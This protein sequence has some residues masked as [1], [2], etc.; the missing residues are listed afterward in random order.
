MKHSMDETLRQLTI[1]DYPENLR[2][3]PGPPEQLWLRGALAP[4]GSRYLAVVGSRALS[5]Y[6]RQ[7]CE[8]LIKGLSGHP[9]SIVSG[10]ALGAD[11]TA[12]QAALDAGLHTTAVL[13]SGISDNAISPRTNLELA[14]SILEN[15]GALIS[16]NTPDYTPFPSDFPKRN[17]I[18]AGLSDAVLIIE[19]GERSGTLITA[20]LA[21]EY[22]R[23]LMCIPH[24]ATDP[25]SYGANLF[26]R[27]GAALVTEPRHIL[28]VLG[29]TQ[30]VSDKDELL[31]DAQ[32]SLLTL[33]ETPLHKEELIDKSAL[34][35]TETLTALVSLE[36][37][38]LVRERYGKWEQS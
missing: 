22:S 20:R 7:M 35:T 1:E 30:D 9:I 27:L 36:M 15:G 12:H 3:I 32:Q 19:A 10:L 31:T 24:N 21:G 8:L 28:E 18:V 4:P 5:P 34:P 23:D 17:R 6:G 16:E 11:A 25:G 2:Q 33:L 38:G 26:I 13:A 37:K 14:R 29:L